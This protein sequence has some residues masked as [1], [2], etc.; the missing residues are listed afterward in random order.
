MCAGVDLHS[1]III[2]VSAWN[3]QEQSADTSC[4][5]GPSAGFDSRL[6]YMYMY[7]LIPSGFLSNSQHNNNCHWFID[8]QSKVVLILLE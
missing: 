5:A 8:A 3:D 1:A 2:F 7:I 4:S 6:P